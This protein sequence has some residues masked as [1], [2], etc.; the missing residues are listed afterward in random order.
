MIT[1]EELGQAIATRRKS[2]KLTQG[3][4]ASRARI[5][6]STL[7]ALENGRTGELGFSK[8]SRI[9][10]ALDMSLRVIDA[11]ARRPTLEDLLSE[12]DD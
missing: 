2:L 6:R 5:G 1:L 9:L 12:D 11:P 10:A 3:A 8:V 4:L 7:D